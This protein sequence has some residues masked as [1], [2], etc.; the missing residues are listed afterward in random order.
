[1]NSPATLSTPADFCCLECGADWFS[2]C[3]QFGCW[4][5]GSEDK[6]NPVAHVKIAADSVSLLRAGTGDVERLLDECLPVVRS[7]YAAWIARHRP[8]LSE[9]ISAT[10]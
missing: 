7:F 10:A 9:E 6:F 1:M 5:C 4:A 2:D 8:D 3:D